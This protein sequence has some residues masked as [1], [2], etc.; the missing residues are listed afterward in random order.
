MKELPY[1][2]SYTNTVGGG[3]MSAAAPHFDPMLL[4]VH[5]SLGDATLSE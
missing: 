4:T 2:D 1:P 3:A 5:F